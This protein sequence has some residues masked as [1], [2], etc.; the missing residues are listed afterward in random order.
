VILPSL[1][2]GGGSSGYRQILGLPGG[3]IAG[4]S[5]SINTGGGGGSGIGDARSWNV[6]KG[7][8]GVVIMRY[9]GAPQALGGIITTVGG[10]TVHT[11]TASGDFILL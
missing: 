1:G 9:Q 3:N 8:S 7:G 6:A 2:G 11:F 10:D 5:G 4:M